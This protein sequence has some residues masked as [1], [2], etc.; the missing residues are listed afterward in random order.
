MELAI[1]VVNAVAMSVIAWQAYETRRQATS[2]SKQVELAHLQISADHE[3]RKKQATIEYYSQLR[4]ARIELQATVEAHFGRETIREKEILELLERE[5]SADKSAIEIARVLREYLAG[6]ERLCV[7]VNTGVFDFDVV[8]RLGGGHISNVFMRHSAYI[9]I[10]RRRN[11]QPTLYC[12]LERLAN[13]LRL[14]SNTDDS[15][16]LTEL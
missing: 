5:A 8:R 16:R 1:L 11:Q 12:E 13:E 4:S 10:A 15:G 3:R 7:G 6:L 2:A 14:A 9:I